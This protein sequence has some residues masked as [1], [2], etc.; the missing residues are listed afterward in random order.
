ML[1]GPGYRLPSCRGARVVPR[2]DSRCL[3]G[4]WDWLPPGPAMRA[5]GIEP[6]AQSPDLELPGLGGVP[7]PSGGFPTPL[8]LSAPGT[9]CPGLALA[10][11]SGPAG[12][13]TRV[14]EALPLG[15]YDHVR[16]RTGKRPA[17]P[18]LRLH[19]PVS[20]P[21]SRPGGPASPSNGTAL[22]QLSAASRCQVLSR[23]VAGR[24]PGSQ[25]R[26]VQHVETVS[27][28]RRPTSDQRTT[29]PPHPHLDR[30]THPTTPTP[31]PSSRPPR[32]RNPCLAPA[33]PTKGTRPLTRACARPRAVV[34]YFSSLWRKPI[35]ISIE[36][37]TFNKL[38]PLVTSNLILKLPSLL[39][40]Y[41][42]LP[43]Q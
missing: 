26:L 37:P 15:V 16:F 31:K 28:P 21:D 30:Q 10:F 36:P 23:P 34:Y 2:E 33:R 32:C 7:R 39:D 42:T 9:P 14:R 25:P 18:R 40:V 1:A 13:R 27:G 4:R 29:R 24:A 20:S 12:N 19:P 3:P 17:V 5:A 38:S 35:E 11:Q 8:P 43:T 22:R 6:A 41:R